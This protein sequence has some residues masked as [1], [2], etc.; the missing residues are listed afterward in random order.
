MSRGGGNTK[1]SLQEKLDSEIKVPK[2]V[3]MGT[4]TDSRYRDQYWLECE[5]YPTLVR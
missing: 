5:R 3:P 4:G 2:E 1:F